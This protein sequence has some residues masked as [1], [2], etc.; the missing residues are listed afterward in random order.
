MPLT[1]RAS[2]AP[3]TLR[4]VD[5]VTPLAAPVPRSV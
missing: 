4:G 2:K 1:R 3:S 5:E